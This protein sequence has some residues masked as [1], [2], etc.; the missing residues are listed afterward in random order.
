MNRIFIIISRYVILRRANNVKT[1]LH[2]RMEKEEEKNNKEGGS[3]A[4]FKLHGKW[5]LKSHENS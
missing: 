2:K 5:C 3:I 1:V 4:V